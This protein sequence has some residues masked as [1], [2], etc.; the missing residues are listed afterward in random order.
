MRKIARMVKTLH[1]L[2]V[3]LP[4]H[5]RQPQLWSFIDRLLATGRS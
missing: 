3:P 4:E 1:S 2:S 5:Q